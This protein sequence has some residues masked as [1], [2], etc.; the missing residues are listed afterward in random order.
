MTDKSSG[1]ER[2]IRNKLLLVVLA[3]VVSIF[4]ISWMGYRGSRRAIEKQI[5]DAG[6][7]VSGL[8]ASE[9]GM[10]LI[11]R[12]EMLKALRFAI[13]RDAQARGYFDPN[14]AFATMQYWQKQADALGINTIFLVTTDNKMYDTFDW[15]I[16]DDYI[17]VEQSWYT[18]TIDASGLTYS[19]PYWD[20]D[21]GEYV[22]LTIGVPMDGPNGERIGVLATDVPLND[23]S[24]FA[25]SRG[26][27]G[28]GYGFIV[29]GDGLVT[30][31]PNKAFALE[32]DITRPSATVPPE[33]AEAGRRMIAGDSGEKSYVFEGVKRELFY[34]PLRGGWSIGISVPYDRLMA[35]AR[36]LAWRQ[37]LIGGT[38]LLL[39]CV[40]S[41]FVYR[42]ISRPIRELVAATAEV[43][44]GNLAH[45][46]ALSG[47]SELSAVAEAV[48]G[49]AAAQRDFFVKLRQ[50]GTEIDGRTRELEDI[51]RDAGHMVSGIA[52]EAAGLAD[53]AER[54]AREVERVN[55]GMDEMT[56]AAHSAAQSTSEVSA[57]AEELRAN[58]EESETLLEQNL[59]KVV[60]ISKA[61]D[62]IDT[63]VREL[64]VNA[65]NIRN[66]VSLI[67]GIAG[68]TNLLALNAAI[69]A[70]RAGE[71]GRGF[72][73]VADEVRNLAEESNE[74][75]ANIGEITGRIVGEV[76]NAV[77]TVRRGVT[78]AGT[79]SEE[80]RETRERV[81]RL[82]D[83]I[84]TIS[85]RI[86]D[87]AS[88]SQEQSASLDEAREALRLIAEGAARNR[89]E[90]GRISGEAED[91]VRR[92]GETARVADELRDMVERNNAHIGK[93]RLDGNAPDTKALRG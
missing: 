27:D 14:E 36:A 53:L 4:L 92:I 12:E 5:L 19:S 81:A 82:I 6:Q 61:F 58:A 7:A 39:L 71:S 42:S 66:I 26:I 62:E 88:V 72:A 15:E 33:L 46:V 10:F 23:L 2:M 3:M 22:I 32:L 25:E 84:G 93:Y 44:D 73:V 30:I 11:E 79:A 1:G 86:E 59:Q 41:W 34:R 91:V 50:Q 89:E 60:E 77:E 87:I 47:K 57:E 65:G 28:E 20:E 51:F 56:A 63:V 48:G 78:L 43:R 85:E 17:P 8:A 31:H 40:L 29:D 49:L 52:G 64:E 55:G 90:T 70:A 45:N 83:G 21:T 80:S 18:D 38:A 9:A 74:A 67:T 13:E 37:A 75:A 54:N 68:Q 16:P 35:P 76:A 69:E 24:K